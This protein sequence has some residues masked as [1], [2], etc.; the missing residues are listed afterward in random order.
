[1]RHQPK[2]AKIARQGLDTLCWVVYDDDEDGETGAPTRM[3][4]QDRENSMST[5]I[6]R[7]ETLRQ[8]IR[9]AGCL[10]AVERVQAA[11]DRLKFCREANDRADRL[12]AL[13]RQHRALA[14]AEQG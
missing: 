14:A 10:L 6:D 8:S 1:M 9:L 7:I 5:R 4:G 12:Q 2:W 3:G 13:R 11:A